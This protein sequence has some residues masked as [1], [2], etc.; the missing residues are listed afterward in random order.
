MLTI[1]FIK[2][3]RKRL[4]SIFAKGHADAAIA[5]DDLVC[6]A[7]ST[8]IQTAELG[9]SSYAKVIGP[10]ER[11]KAAGRMSIVVGTEFRDRPDVR[12]ILGTAELAIEA[13]AKQ[14]PAN[15]RYLSETDDAEFG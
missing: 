13:L 3:S 1:R 12:A 15:V 11:D 14:Y 2:D 5:G 6:A 4:S 9:L 8:I 7:A 10:V